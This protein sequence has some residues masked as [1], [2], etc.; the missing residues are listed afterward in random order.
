MVR[1]VHVP[2]MLAASNGVFL[3]ALWEPSLRM[4]KGK[5]KIKPIKSSGGRE[6][7]KKANLSNHWFGGSLQIFLGKLII[8]LGEIRK[9]QLDTP[10]AIVFLLPL[11][12]GMIFLYYTYLLKFLKKIENFRKFQVPN[13]KFSKI[14]H[15]QKRG[16]KGSRTRI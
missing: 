13:L 2:G 16:L 14:F 15:I 7:P 10:A 12:I 1:E 11:A 5:K 9:Y 6:K 4:K 3:I 8:I